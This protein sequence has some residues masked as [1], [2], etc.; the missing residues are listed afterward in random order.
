M[1]RIRELAALEWELGDW[2]DVSPTVLVLVCG[3]V[4]EATRG[5]V[6]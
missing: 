3:E 6:S 4:A 2:D 1:I 5:A